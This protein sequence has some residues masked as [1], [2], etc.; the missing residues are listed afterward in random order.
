MIVIVQQH[1]Q[2]ELQEAIDYVGDLCLGCIDRF[3]ALRQALPSWGP[4]IDEQLQV[5]IDGLGAWMIGNLVW[6][7]ETER[8]FGKEGRQVRHDLSVRLLPL[9]KRMPGLRDI[10][11]S[12]KLPQRSSKQA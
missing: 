7:F 12:F 5:Y 11:S 9:R 1:E 6:S 3:E 10:A 4:E 8:Y 2:L